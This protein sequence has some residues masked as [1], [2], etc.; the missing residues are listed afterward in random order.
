[1]QIPTTARGSARG[2]AAI[3][4]LWAAWI[5]V[6][7]GLAGAAVA[8]LL[9]FFGERPTPA[10]EAHAG[11][12][13]L[14]AALTAI[15]LPLLGILVSAWTDRRA[16]AVAFSLALALGLLASV[17]LFQAA[18]PDRVPSAIPVH[19]GGGA[20]QEHSGGDTRCPGG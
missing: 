10:E 16:S 2:T 12:L 11:R 5:L 6:P 18:G 14:A 3:V 13:L 19:S 20:C 15:V 8:S 9:T 4:L 1:V 7:L 17:P